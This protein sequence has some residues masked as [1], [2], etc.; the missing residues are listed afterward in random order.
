MGSADTQN[1]QGLRK[2]R[3]DAVEGAPRASIG[4]ITI[5]VIAESAEK[6]S[7]ALN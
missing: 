3:R 2:Q 5:K 6:P 7:N 1:W 4:A